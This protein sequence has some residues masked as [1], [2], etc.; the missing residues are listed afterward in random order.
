M[1]LGTEDYKRRFQN[2]SRD[3]LTL[4]LPRTM[5]PARLLIL[6]EAGARRWGRRIS[7][8][9]AGAATTQALRRLLPTARDF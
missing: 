8:L 7:S 4:V 2:A 5:A 6:A 3:V 9:P 1:L